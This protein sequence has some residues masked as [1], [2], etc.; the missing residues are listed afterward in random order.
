M[1]ELFQFLGYWFMFKFLRIARWLRTRYLFFDSDNP[2]ELNLSS[3]TLYTAEPAAAEAAST[4]PPNVGLP[5]IP[6]M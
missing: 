3:I 1:I 4:T 5:V 2:F 6:S